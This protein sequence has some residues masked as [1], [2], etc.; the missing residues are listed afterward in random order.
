MADNELRLISNR[1]AF[2][3]DNYRLVVLALLV[4]VVVNVG[5]VAIAG[6]QITHKPDPQYFASTTTGRILPLYPLNSAMMSKTEVLQWS[7]MAVIA[8]YTFSF[9]NW[10]KQLEQASNY[11]T[12][13]GWKDFQSS[14]KE[15]N[16][17]KDVLDKKLVMNAVANSTP[18]VE[19]E[20][21]INGDY[22]WK[23]QLPLTLTFQ[24]AATSTTQRNVIV[25]MLITRVPL[26]KNPKGIAIAEFSATL[27][28]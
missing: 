5:L 25:N 6:Y 1:D 24:S 17:L 11:F 27:Q 7:N 10:Q 28:R 22:T 20:G 13:E 23:V 14:L 4:L 15:S 12:T 2:Y 9:V 21:I 16:V 18:V 3:R 19:Q 26:S 8:A